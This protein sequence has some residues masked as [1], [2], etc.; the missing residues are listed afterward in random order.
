MVT[1]E[2]PSLVGSSLSATS[3]RKLI[4][5][6]YL[7]EWRFCKHSM[8]SFTFGLNWSSVPLSA[9][10]KQLSTP[11][12]DMRRYFEPDEEGKAVSLTKG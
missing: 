4:G 8:P 9:I 11:S 2:R 3:T 5:C 7:S 6:W 10:L 1:S 12:P